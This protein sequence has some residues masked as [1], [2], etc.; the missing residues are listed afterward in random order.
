[1]FCFLSLSTVQRRVL[2]YK[3]YTLVLSNDTRSVQIKVDKGELRRLEIPYIPKIKI[4]RRCLRLIKS[5]I[6][7]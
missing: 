4:L 6:S 7:L 5:L 3:L 2:I 1:M